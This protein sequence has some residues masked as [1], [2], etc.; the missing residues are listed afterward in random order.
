MKKIIVALGVAAVALGFSSCNNEGST[1][2]SGSQND[3][4]PILLG[5]VQGASYLQ[6]WD[7]LPDTMKAKLSKDKFLEGFKAVISR[8]PKE[9]QAYI[10]GMSTALQVTSNLAQMQEA[11]VKFNKEVF[12]SHF[13]EAFKK[14]SVDRTALMDANEELRI[15]MNE[16]NELIMK[17]QQ[18]DQQAAMAAKQAD[19]EPAIKAGK[20]FIE[21][22]KKADPS[23]KTTESGVC[24][25][26]VKEGSGQK[27]GRKDRVKVNYTGKHIDGTEFDSSKG[28]PRDFRVDGVVP[29][30]A[31]VLQMM[32]PGAKYIAYIPYDKAYGLNGAGDIKPGET[33]VFE[34][35]MVSVLPNGK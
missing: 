4:L 8:D 7:Q 20:E 22:Q 14:D 31:E 5:D 9:D 15:Y 28:E 13:A 34:I 1:A 21:A 35:E 18:A 11:G 24:Y 33:L 30:F 26:V 16:V 17:K 27:P 23:I 10:M 6:M 2:G 25:K 3:S 12:I 32:A 29:G 19:A